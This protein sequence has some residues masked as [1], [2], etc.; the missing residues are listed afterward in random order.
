MWR[1]LITTAFAIVLAIAFHY[2]KQLDTTYGLV[3]VLAC[4]PLMAWLWAPVFMDLASRG[5][6]FAKSLAYGSL[7]GKH[8]S[9]DGRRVRFFLANET[10]WVAESDLAGILVQGVTDRERRQLRE[11]YGVIPGKRLK[12]FT[13]VGIKG[14]LAARLRDRHASRELL[15]FNRWL[16]EEA[17]PNVRRLPGSAA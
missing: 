1:Y 16:H 15:R 12:G 5:I 7:Q 14:L 6:G 8:Y 4:A 9:F 17:L 10:I 3:V 13:E 2:L 11:A